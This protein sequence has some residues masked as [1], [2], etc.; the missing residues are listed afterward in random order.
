MSP[1]NTWVIISSLTRISAKKVNDSR[2]LMGDPSRNNRKRTESR[3]HGTDPENGGDLTSTP[4]LRRA[5]TGS[6]PRTC[7][8]ANTFHPPS[9]V[10]RPDNQPLYFESQWQLAHDGV[11]LSWHNVKPRGGGRLELRTGTSGSA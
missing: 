3:D 4:N 2:C 5:K 11:N 7:Q 9:T 8:Q 6:P 10:N 1:T